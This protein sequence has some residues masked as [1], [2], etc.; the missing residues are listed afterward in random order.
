MYQYYI[1]QWTHRSNKTVQIKWTKAT[2]VE[3]F[4]FSNSHIL[5]KKGFTI[6]LNLPPLI[7]LNAGSTHD[8][9]IKWKYF[10]RYWPLVW[11]TGKF[12]AQRPVTR[13]FG[14]FFNLR[15]NKRLSKQ[16]WRGDLR[17][18]HVYYDVTV[19]QRF[20]RN[21]NKDWWNEYV[22]SEKYIDNSN[23]HLRIHMGNG[24]LHRLSFNIRVDLA[25]FGSYRLGVKL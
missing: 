21:D 23:T 6:I 14:V 8:D 19:M 25:T 5:A 9:I 3:Y 20:N 17:L 22:M 16:S 12:P 15:L 2:K 1:Q 7:A 10:P 11:V 13:S 24:Q 4:I 18:H